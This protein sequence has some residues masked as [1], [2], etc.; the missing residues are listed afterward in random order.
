MN[1]PLYKKLDNTQNVDSI[2]L[3]IHAPGTVPFLMNKG[4]N[5]KS[6]MSTSVSLMMKKFVRLGAPYTKCQS[7]AT[8]KVDS[9]T[10][11]SSSDVCREKCIINALR[12]KCNCTSTLFEDLAVSDH[13]YGFCL[14]L[15]DTFSLSQTI[16]PC[17]NAC[18][19]LPAE[20]RFRLD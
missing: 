5:L 7:E 17:I 2:R 9:R 8:F 19:E 15:S 1:G 14:N 6:G 10:F 12:K 18:T 13:D 11:L 16:M 3:A 4:I 20:N